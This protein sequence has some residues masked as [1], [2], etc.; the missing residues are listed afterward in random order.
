M[1]LENRRAVTERKV[2]GYFFVDV[3]NVYKVFFSVI[4]FIHYSPKPCQKL[5]LVN[6]SC[7]A[8]FMFKGQCLK[9]I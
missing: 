5:Y 6:V 9:A 4:L 1:T 8:G 7:R 3:I 2:I